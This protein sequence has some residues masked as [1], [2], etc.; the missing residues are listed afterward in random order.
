MTTSTPRA[1]RSNK[2]VSDSPLS[3]LETCL[4]PLEDIDWSLVSAHHY[5][6]VGT[7]AIGR[8]LAELM[9]WF[10]MKRCTL[11]DHKQYKT[12]S[13]VSQCGPDEV[14]RPKATV[15]ADELTKLGV[16]AV[17]H[18]KDIETVPAGHVE[19]DTVMI[20]GVDNRR[21]DILANRWAARMRIRLVKVN[22]EPRLLTS[23]V[24]AYDFRSGSSQ[25][26]LECQMSDEQY[27]DQLHPLSCDG[28]EGPSTGSPRAL[29]VMAAGA[30]AM[31]VVQIVGSPDHGA[32]SWINRQW[33]LSMLG[34][35]STVSKL[36]QKQDCRWNHANCWENLERLDRGPR[37]L[38][39]ADLAA[40]VSARD[41]GGTRFR[42]SGQVSTEQRCTNCL[43]GYF[44]NR[45]VSQLDEPL[46]TCSCGGGLRAVPHFLCSE[47][48]PSELADVWDW[49]LADWHVPPLAIIAHETD[50]NQ[51][52]FVIGAES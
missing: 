51:S 17:P 3:E 28:R 14:G 19:Q 35:Y 49:P 2:P 9:A 13:V 34:G 41:A 18:V 1:K 43:K 4:P 31:A 6:F 20:V 11:I 38:T 40:R 7:G 52:T 47:L 30:A 42:F 36:S 15:V 10:G 50:R 5:M 48:S 33:Q 39:L 22:V 12:Q 32:N 29:S 23:S 37:E 8:P 27:V 45:W 26:C 24:R 46:G 16:A 21:A 25:I 44:Q